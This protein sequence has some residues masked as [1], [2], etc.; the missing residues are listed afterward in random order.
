MSSASSSP[1]IIHVVTGPTA[2]GKSAVAMA[3]AERFGLG[4]ISADSRQIY[5]GFDIGTAKPS[6][7]DRVRVPHAGIDVCAP[8]ERYSAHRWASDCAVWRDEFTRAGRRSLIVGGTGFYIRALVSPLDAVPALDATR[9][10]QLEGWLE[11]LD[12]PTLERWC[13]RLDPARAS[14]GRTQR[15]RAVETALLS[16]YPISEFLSATV[17]ATAPTF[18]PRVRYLVVDPGADLKQRIETRVDDMFA[19][20]WTDEVERLMREVPADAPA[21]KAS[22]YGAVRDAVSGRCSVAAARARVV[23]ETRQY[24]KR[25][26]TW[27]RHQLTAADVTWLDSHAADATARARAWWESDNG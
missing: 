8:T 17:G 13:R 19:H 10:A 20:G 3:L 16:G 12:A 11:T 18:A 26:R 7:A 2:A 6:A 27:N 25:Q 14:L 9:R 4:I 24:A 22:G 23:I 15:L 21:W 5:R 1:D